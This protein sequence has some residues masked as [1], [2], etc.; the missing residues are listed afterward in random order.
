M[1]IGGG[2]L[3]GWVIEPLVR[4]H[5]RSPFDCGEPV[6]DEFLKTLARQQQEKNVGRTFVAVLPG[7]KRVLGFYTL[8]AGSIA[9]RSMP[10]DLRRKIPKYPVP[11]ARLGRLA[12]D[13]SVEG[14]GLGSALLRDA[15]LRTAR[16]ASTEM[17]IVAVVVD[18]KNEAAKKFYERYGFIPFADSPLSLFMLTATI[19]A[20]IGA[21]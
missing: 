20:G 2:E 5:Q 1:A 17:G 12:V 4:D 16:I 3:A 15:L 10:A 11:V 6:L 13:L 14:K 18:A 21:T 9:A 19:L 7:S 8:S